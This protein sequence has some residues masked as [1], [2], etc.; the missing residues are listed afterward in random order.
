MFY[1]IIWG[2]DGIVSQKGG[3]QSHPVLEGEGGL[4]DLVNNPH[5]PYN[6]CDTDY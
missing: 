2:V 6:P 1:F 5:E 4:S 3:R